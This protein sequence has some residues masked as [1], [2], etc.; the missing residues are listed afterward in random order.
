MAYFP[1]NTVPSDPLIYY[2][3]T[4]GSD[5]T[6]DGTP[7]APFASWQKAIDVGTEENNFNFDFGVGNFG[8]G[9]FEEG[10]TVTCTIRGAGKDLTT[11]GEVE[12]YGGGDLTLVDTRGQSCL[13][14]L[15]YLN[16]AGQAVTGGAL[17]VRDI[18]TESPISSY[19][20][21]SLGPGGN[22]TNGGDIAILGCCYIGGGVS[23]EGGSGTDSPDPM[24]PGG[25]G[26]NAGNITI[27]GPS[28]IGTQ[29]NANGGEAGDNFGG[30]G[31]G[32]NGIGG[33]IILRQICDVPT[34][35][36]TSGGS[37]TVIAAIINGVFTGS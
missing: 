33:A 2:I 5:V 25:D 32:A 31:A 10:S 18:Y 9:E 6:G 23:S 29:V 8:D 30:G 19:G 4:S 12:L 13:L 24:T 28:I 15:V 1:N 3:R 35:T 22:G 20:S 17:T 14:G 21:G 37:V 11:L 26:G 36:A 27:I 34:P 16:D 7:G